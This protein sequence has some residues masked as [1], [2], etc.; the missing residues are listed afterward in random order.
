[1]FPADQRRKPRQRSDDRIGLRAMPLE[2]GTGPVD[3]DGSEAER[4]RANDI[5]AVR[6]NEADPDRQK[7]EVIYGELV[8]A[9]ARLVNACGIDGQNGVEMQGYSGRRRQWFKHLARAVGRSEER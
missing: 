3:P 8:D 2:R 7:L 4:L 9:G 6:R 5:P 1:Q